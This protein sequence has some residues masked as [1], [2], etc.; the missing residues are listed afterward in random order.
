MVGTHAVVTGANGA[1]NGHSAGHTDARS[2]SA[3]LSVGP[4]RP[5]MTGE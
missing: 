3:M 4:H 1:T 2:P 5:G